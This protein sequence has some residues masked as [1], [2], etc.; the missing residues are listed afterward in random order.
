MS[1][2]KTNTALMPQKFYPSADDSTFSS[3][4]AAYTRV[5]Y[6]RIGYANAGSAGSAAEITK[7][8][9]VYGRRDAASRVERLKL[10]AIGQSSMRLKEIEELRFK[11]PNVND[12]RDALR[13]SRSHGYVVP[14]KVVNR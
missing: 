1:I 4:R 14:P 2:E 13:R 8:N 5:A 6:P 7:R 9:L 10:Q 12:A 11:A 3:A